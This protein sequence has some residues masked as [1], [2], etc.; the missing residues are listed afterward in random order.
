MSEKRI[1]LNSAIV[2]KA[3]EAIVGSIK[4]ESSLGESK[5]HNGIKV[6]LCKMLQ[7]QSKRHVALETLESIVVARPGTF[8]DMQTF[9]FRLRVQ[10][11]CKDT[12]HGLQ[13][14]SR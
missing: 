8:V 11:D 14:V 1:L 7:L 12:Y 10:P 2:Y 9:K 5:V 6:E 4:L 3:G 13:A